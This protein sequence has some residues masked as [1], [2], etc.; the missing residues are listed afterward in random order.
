MARW[1]RVLEAFADVGRMGH[2]RPRPRHGHPAQRGPPDPPR[3][4]RARAAGPGRRSRPLPR[5]R[6]PRPD[7]PARRRAPRYPPRGPAV[8]RAGLGGHRRDGR[9]RRLRPGPPPVLGRRRGRDQPPHPLLCGSR[10]GTGATSTSAR[11][12]RAS[13]PSCR[14]TS[15]PPSSTACPDPV[16]GPHRPDQGQAARGAARPTASA[17]TSSAT[18]SAT[19]ARSGSRRRSATHAAGSSATSSRRGP[20]TA[21]IAPRRSPPGS[22]SGPPRTTCRD[23]SAGPVGSGRHLDRSAAPGMT[24][25]IRIGIV[26][27]GRIVAAEHVPRFRAID[28]VELVGVANRSEESSRRAADELGLARA[29][30]SWQA[31]V[32]D[33]GARRVL[34]GA[35]PVLHAPVTIAALEAG[36]HVLT[37]ARMAATAEDARAML[38]AARAHPDHVAMVVPASSPP[39]RTRTIVRLLRDGAIGRVRHVAGRAGIRAAPGDPGDFWRW[40]RVDERREHHGPR[41][42]RRG[43]DPL[44]RPARGGHRRHAP[45]PRRSGPD[46]PARSRPT[47]PTTSWPS[48]STR[49]T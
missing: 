21:P 9:H 15:R 41:H 8:P 45:R 49:T 28:G 32:A 34:V 27:A 3:H 14:P 37:E 17:A 18:A 2:P 11:R 5:R 1:V 43:D 46:R 44:A 39:G 7:R 10:C 24:D 23:A 47:S 38:R 42:P 48:S 19:R 29:Y 40:Q 33:P 12:A 25:P 22:S 35:W 4:G 13:W 16:P 30:P 36:K 6:G 26:G 20:T 31:L